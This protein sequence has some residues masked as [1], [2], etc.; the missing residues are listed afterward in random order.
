MNKP[1]P[2]VIRNKSAQRERVTTVLRVIVGPATE[3]G[4][5]AQGLD[6]DYVSTGESAEE[7]MRNFERGFVKTVM[8]IL[9]R[10]RPLESLFKSRAPVEAWEAY[11]RSKDANVFSCTVSRDLSAEV[12]EPAPSYLSFHESSKSIAA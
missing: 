4:F 10:G 12:P 7:A 1:D 11:E 8:A 6:I 3:G 5:V 9:R 2:V